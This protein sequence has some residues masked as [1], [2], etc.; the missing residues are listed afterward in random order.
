MR[1]VIYIFLVICLAMSSFSSCSNS[2]PSETLT[3][4]NY[5]NYLEVEE[6]TCS[7]WGSSST[8]FYYDFNS[9]AD[10]DR[11]DLQA[12]KQIR[13]AVEI[14]GAS[15]QYIY[16]D[17]SVTLHFE[18]KYTSFGMLLYSSSYAR[19]FDVTNDA[20]ERDVSFDITVKGNVAGNGDGVF[21]LDIP[22]RQYSIRDYFDVSCEVV[23]VSGSVTLASDAKR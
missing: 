9:R 19:F 10:I 15:T 22:D 2:T 13:F 7:N 18:G 4:E 3:M 1:K 12:Y 20:K 16:N 23:S 8:V 17:V 14:K 21:I 11:T 6:I 5:K